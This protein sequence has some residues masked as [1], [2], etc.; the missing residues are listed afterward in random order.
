MG[1]PLGAVTRETNKPVRILHVL[2]S[3]DPGGV[4]TWLLQVLRAID[5]DRFQFDFCTFGS[6]GGVY[7]AEVKQLGAKIVPCLRGANPWA[8]RRRFER[9][10]R[11]T[12]YDVV[13]SHVHLFSGA[14]VRWAKAAQVP[15]RIAHSHTSR[16]DK[17]DTLARRSYSRLMH[18]WISRYATHGLAA[19]RLAAAELFGHNWQIDARLHVLHYGID[20][21]P[22]QE[23]VDREEVRRELGIPPHA[24]VVGH[25]GRFVEA[26]NHHFLLRIAQEILKNR[27]DVH[28]LL[29]G[30]GPLRP[31][32]EASVRAMGFVGNIHFAGTRTDVARLMGGAMDL[33]VFPSLY[34]GFGLTVVEAQ[35][36]GLRSV[37][38]DTV[39]K[40]TAVSPASVEFLAL[41][42]GANYWASRVMNL[43]EAARSESRSAWSGPHGNHFSIHRSVQ[44]LTRI[45]D[46]VPFSV[47]M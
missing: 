1:A 41:D 18:S 35:A 39:S 3:L 34:E 42:A 31:K 15:T 17:P 26:K 4:E 7:A 46:Y 29:V 47:A 12:R 36:A 33:F 24:L 20:L 38:S 8:F 44:E 30:G 16:D 37:V 28:F 40:E 5:R 9:I 2:G 22:F 6:E 25:V 13:H 27:P 19:S 21:L 23:P 10:L 11:G 32:I 43:L 45:Y 14:V